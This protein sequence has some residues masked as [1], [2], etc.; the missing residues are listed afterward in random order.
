M[1]PSASGLPQRLSPQDAEARI[2]KCAPVPAMSSSPSWEGNP[3]SPRRT[4]PGPR[5]GRSWSARC[6]SATVWFDLVSL[7]P[8]TYLDRP[9][10]NRIDLMEK[11]AAMHP[12]FLRLPGGN[13][14]EGNHIDERFQWKKTIGPWVDRPTHPSQWGF[15]SS[16]GMG[17]LEFLKWCE[18]LKIE[19][20][21][22]VY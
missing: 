14:L 19:P 8:P 18:D 2:T 3:R 5:A 12:N 10:G 1:V 7:F 17:L 13:Y 20:V 9:H 4:M 11:L 16:D 6:F 15:S 22:A 21:L